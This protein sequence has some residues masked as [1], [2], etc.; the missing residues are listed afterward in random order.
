MKL[1]QRYFILVG[2]RRKRININNGRRKHERHS[3]IPGIKQ[4]T[5][6]VILMLHKGTIDPSQFQR[7]LCLCHCTQEQ[8]RISSWIFYF[9]A[10]HSLTNSL[11]H[12]PC[13]LQLSIAS[14]LTKIAIGEGQ[15]GQ[16]RTYLL[17]RD[18]SSTE[19]GI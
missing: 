8:L 1:L 6:I 11:L 4:I 10:S 13:L 7:M 2:S 14:I 19:R 16:L 3:Q 15:P 17:S 18:S 9:I 5:S 12:I